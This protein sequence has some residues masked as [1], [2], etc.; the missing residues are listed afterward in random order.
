MSFFKELFDLFINLQ[1]SEDR[2]ICAVSD[3]IVV[4]N[5]GE[6]IV[7][8]DESNENNPSFHPVSKGIGELEE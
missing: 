6:V 2:S 3:G 1:C 7:E 4:T 5:N 8:C